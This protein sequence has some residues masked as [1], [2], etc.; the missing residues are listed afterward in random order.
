LSLSFPR[1]HPRSA[2]LVTVTV[3]L[4][5]TALSC[6]VKKEK[7]TVSP[8]YGQAKTLSRTEILDLYHRLCR[9]HQSLIVKSAS[10]TFSAESIQTA[11]REK[12]P[13]ADGILI[14]TRSGNLRLQIQ[15]PMIK[16]TAL[17]VV[18]KQDRFEIWYPRK[19]TLYRGKMGD[20]R[21]ELPPME[22]EPGEKAPRYNLSRL[23]PWHITQTFFLEVPGENPAIL[24]TQEDTAAE[25]YYVLHILSMGA[26]GT[27]VIVQKL[28]LERAGLTVRKKVLFAEDGAPVS[29]ITYQGYTDFPGGRFPADITLRRPLEGYQVQFRIK[30]MELD[31]PLQD[32]MF[33][34]TVPEGAKIEEIHP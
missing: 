4:L 21:I 14:V 6:G 24:V 12:L 23:R 30:R 16:T 33:E 29:E 15:L 19:Q 20:E 25:R 5:G 8:A 11:Q 27:P 3:L 26:G 7:I 2:R 31:A 10:L 32:R 1:F 17:D 9:E 18:A 34:L 13:S 22:E 28:W